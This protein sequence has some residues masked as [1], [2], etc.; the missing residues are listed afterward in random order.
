MNLNNMGKE[1]MLGALV[2]DIIGSTY[3]FYN[4]KRTDFELFEN[5][6]RFTDDSVMTLA[7]AKWLLEDSADTIHYLIYCMQELGDH[8]PNAGYGG[9]FAG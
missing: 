7:V 2:G 5:S 9:R 6:C 4:T 8:H 3:E 1:K